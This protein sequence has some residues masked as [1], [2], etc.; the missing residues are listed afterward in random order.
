MVRPISNDTSSDI[1]QE[2]DAPL[3]FIGDI[4]SS[5]EIPDGA[6]ILIVSKD[7]SYLTHGIHKFPAKF[8]PELPR[9]LIQRY[10]EV[11]DTILDPMCG[12]GTTILE[13]A[14]C[15][16]K[17]IGID[18]DSI[19]RLIT[20]VKT[21]PIDPAILENIITSLTQQIQK[22]SLSSEYHPEI[23]VFNYRDNWFRPHVL[24][25]LC[26]I[27]DCIESLP[28]VHDVYSV[29]EWSDIRDFFRIAMSSIIR[30]VSNADPHCTRTVLRKKVIKKIDPGDTISKFLVALFE[31]AKAM[32]DLWSVY[33]SMKNWEV[34]IPEGTA[35]NTGLTDASVDLV[36]T[37]PPYINAVD[38]PRTHQLEMYW[39]GFLGD[40]SLSTVKRKYIGTET[41]YKR[42]YSEL[43]VSGLDS[44]DPVLKEIFKQDP[45][46]SFITYMFFRDMETQLRETMRVLKPGGRYCIAIGSN[47]IR[48][49]QVKSH[50]ILSE[51]STVNVGFE[52]ERTFFSK[53][54][55]HFI[56]IPRK[57]R[58]LGE[59]I[60]IL[61]KPS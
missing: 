21:T 6:D 34:S 46:R 41:V 7:Q 33:S 54:I 57:E 53:L 59:W 18:I 50:E 42:E 24:S 2:N 25:E 23:P 16:R 29:H 15:R 47:L 8:F 39:L 56:R 9:Y 22:Y 19:A 49:V 37:S 4:D 5:L 44:L 11:N 27:R 30:D 52:L 48:G 38:Y 3:E 58:M 43:S 60:L 36:V 32:K 14:L 35:T 51:I 55:R 17:S 28:E 45:R 61:K 26:I 20:H 10:S 31:Q 12:S 1:H 40:E 13:A